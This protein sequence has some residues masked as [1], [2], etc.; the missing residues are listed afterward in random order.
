MVNS[1]KAK[2]QCPFCEASF[3]VLGKHLKHCRKRDG[4]PYEMFLSQNITRRPSKPKGVSRPEQQCPKCLKTFQRLDLHLRR[5]ATC[6]PQAQAGKMNLVHQSPQQQH[7][8]YASDTQQMS[9]TTT[10]SIDTFQLSDLPGFTP[11]PIAIRKH[12]KVPRSRDKKTWLELNIQIAGEVVPK[13]LDA[14]SLE[15]KCEVLTTGIYHFLSNLTPSQPTKQ[16]SQHKPHNRQLKGVTERKKQLKK[17]LREANR[18]NAPKDAIADLAKQYHQCVRLHSKL[19]NVKRKSDE[20]KN[21]SAIRRECARNFWKFS[22][23]LLGETTE[24]SDIQPTCSADDAH[25]YFS[26]EYSHR[27]TP[28]VNPS[29]CPQ[30]LNHRTLSNVKRYRRRSCT[31][32]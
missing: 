20:R 1:Q 26:E 8:G 32:P 31:R 6:S 7:C 13:V 23:T 12:V 25:S 9:S 5:S 16:K 18:M 15:E 14:R 21:A 10:P 2:T 30:P 19:T 22:N 29:G 28:S 17:D 24:A 11:S 27:N 4:R 3:T